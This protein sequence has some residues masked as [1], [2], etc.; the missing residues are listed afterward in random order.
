M[1]TYTILNS[2]TTQKVLNSDGVQVDWLDENYITW[3]G[4]GIMPNIV[5]EETQ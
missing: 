1:T 3:L 4:Q 5:T 2:G